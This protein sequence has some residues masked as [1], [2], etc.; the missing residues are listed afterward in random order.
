MA[1]ES[2]HTFDIKIKKGKA[3]TIE[4]KKIFE[5]K[6]NKLCFEQR[7][8]YTITPDSCYKFEQEK[9]EFNTSSTERGPLKFKPTHFKIEGKLLL[10]DE[11]Q[12]SKIRMIVQ[13]KNAPNNQEELQLKKAN[14]TLYSF[15]HYTPS[16]KTIVIEPQLK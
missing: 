3:A 10:K 5:G 2:T 15:E 4:K 7:G 8:S 9:F 1:Y 12:V 16:D 6:S 14:E 11:D 13:N